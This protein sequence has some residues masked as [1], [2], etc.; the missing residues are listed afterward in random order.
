MKMH[1]DTGGIR[2]LTTG[3][4]ASLGEH[5]AGGEGLGAGRHGEDESGTREHGFVLMEA[6]STREIAYF[7]TTQ[8]RLPVQAVLK[9]QM[10]STRT[11]NLFWRPCTQKIWGVS[12]VS[13]QEGEDSP[14]S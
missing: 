5:G 8:V 7:L 4:E 9:F 2:I 3:A 11:V 10:Q 6:I 1:T 13:R 12:R 14:C